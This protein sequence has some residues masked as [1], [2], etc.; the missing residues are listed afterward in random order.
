MSGMCHVF[1]N[2]GANEIVARV[3]VRGDTTEDIERCQYRTR[4]LVHRANAYPKLVEALEAIVDAIDTHG[5]WDM[6]V[7]TERAQE[8]ARKALAST[9]EDR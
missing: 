2:D 7:A 9:K 6:D 3:D 4:A 5:E 1:V 8:I